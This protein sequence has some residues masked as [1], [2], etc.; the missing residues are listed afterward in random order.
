MKKFSNSY[1]SESI[2]EVI[3]QC[4][5]N[6]SGKKPVNENL[7]L[8]AQW[9]E[10]EDNNDFDVVTVYFYYDNII[11]MTWQERKTMINNS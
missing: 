11:V 3:E 9:E 4:I 7:Y 5:I 2:N 10:L 6:G 1:L 8:S